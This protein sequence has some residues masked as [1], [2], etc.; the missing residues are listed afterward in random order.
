MVQVWLEVVHQCRWGLFL[1]V[2]LTCYQ[3]VD[4]LSHSY[5]YLNCVWIIISCKDEHPLK[6]KRYTI[7]EIGYII[8]TFQSMLLHKALAIAIAILSINGTI[9]PSLTNIKWGKKYSTTSGLLGRGPLLITAFKFNPFGIIFICI[10]GSYT[11][12]LS[13]RIVHNNT[14]LP[15]KARQLLHMPGLF[16]RWISL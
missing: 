2:D 5:F 6:N 11:L 3:T 7:L 4:C 15:A 1:M 9:F 10:P 16:S 13:D 8:H 14:L 12:S